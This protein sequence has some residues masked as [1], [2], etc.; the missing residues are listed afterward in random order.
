MLR[1]LRT[2]RK[3]R[4]SEKCSLATLNCIFFVGWLCRLGWLLFL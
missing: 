1:S 4:S 2:L 3:L